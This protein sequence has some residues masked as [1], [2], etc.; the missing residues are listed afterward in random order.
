VISP[1]LTPLRTIA[2]ALT[3]GLL[4]ACAS[5]PASTP[6][7]SADSEERTEPPRMLSRGSLPSARLSERPTVA[8]HCSPIEHRLRGGS[9]RT[10]EP[11]YDGP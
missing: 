7:S 4:T 8:S 11:S 3:I 2:A 1:R 6:E 10:F 9:R 5:T